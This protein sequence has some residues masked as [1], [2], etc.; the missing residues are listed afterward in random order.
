MIRT[1]LSNAQWERIAPEL[2]GIVAQRLDGPGSFPPGEIER[3]EGVRFR[4]LDEGRDRE[5]RTARHL[6]NGRER[7]CAT[8]GDQLQPVFFGESAR[9]AK[10]EAYRRAVLIQWFECAV[11]CRCIHVD[12]P[13]L[14]PVLAA[15]RT[16]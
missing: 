15:S 6:K 1:V 14:D 13:D 8:C 16:S 9:H 2:P 3:A 10:A 5:L 11:P 4:E 12:R 7:A